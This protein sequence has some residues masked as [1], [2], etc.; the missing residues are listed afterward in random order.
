M[1]ESAFRER[2]IPP[3]EVRK[4]VERASKLSALEP[5]EAGVGQ[6]LTEAELEQ[7]LGDLASL[8]MP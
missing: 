6:A 1:S 2:R 7:R 8:P 4:I 5:A 3:D